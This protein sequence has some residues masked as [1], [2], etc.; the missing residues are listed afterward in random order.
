MYLF[1]VSAG[2]AS[3]VA[4]RVV[5]WPLAAGVAA[6]VALGH[7]LIPMGIGQRLAAA[8]L[9]VWLGTVGWKLFRLHG[10]PQMVYQAV[11]NATNGHRS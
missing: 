8:C 5:S 9:L 11:G 7:S 6:S 3:T 2:L 1:P 10:K 4:P